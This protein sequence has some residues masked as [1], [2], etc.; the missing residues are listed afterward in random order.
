M[1]SRGSGNVPNVGPPWRMRDAAHLTQGCQ[2]QD[3]SNASEGKRLCCYL[4]VRCVAVGIVSSEYLRADFE[5]LRV[6]VR[7]WKFW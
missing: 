4:H 7:T 3:K 6:H 2:K 5:E 1:G